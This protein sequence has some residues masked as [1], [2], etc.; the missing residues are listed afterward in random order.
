M[1]ESLSSDHFKPHMNET[2]T[3]STE[4]VSFDAELVE[5]AERAMPRGGHPRAGAPNAFTLVF[6]APPDAQVGQQT[7][8]VSHPDLGTMQLFLVPHAP[9]DDGRAVYAAVLN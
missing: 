4:E 9:R 5:V 2:F 8:A 3:L 1:L 6:A 7:F